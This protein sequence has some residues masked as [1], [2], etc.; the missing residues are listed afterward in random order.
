MNYSSGLKEKPLR[1]TLSFSTQLKPAL[2][3]VLNT[4][5]Q[6]LGATS[7]GVQSNQ[8]LD[9][10]ACLSAKRSTNARYLDRHPY[11]YFN[12][13]KI[14]FRGEHQISEAQLRSICDAYLLLD[15]GQNILEQ[16]EDKLTGLYRLSG[17]PFAQVYL[18]ECD[19]ESGFTRFD[20]VEGYIDQVLINVQDQKLQVAISPIAQ[21]LLTQSPVNW[22]IFHQYL[23][24]L[25][26]LTAECE[27]ELNFNESQQNPGAV[28]AVICDQENSASNHKTFS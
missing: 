17:Y 15:V 27:L 2:V 28:C 20:I 26:T 9:D 1:I 5:R 7:H 13:Q 19:C 22:K 3:A 24:Q 16:L 10:F 23:V 8:T 11:V 21:Q 12:L 14:D 25:E 4:I 6:K 18:S